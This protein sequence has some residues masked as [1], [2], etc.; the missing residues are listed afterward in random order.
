MTPEFTPWEKIA[1]LN[2]DIVI[3]EKIDGTN[4]AIGVVNVG[5]ETTGDI[6]QVYA[7]SR[8]R[9]ITPQAD[10]FGFAKWV[11][12]NANELAVQLGEGLHFGEWWGRGIQRGYGLDQQRFSL[13]NTARWGYL[14]DPDFIE[15]HPEALCFV[16]PVL[17]EGRFDQSAIETVLSLLRVSGS[18]AAPGY[19]KPEGVVIF[20]T[21]ANSMF[22]VTLEGDAKPKG[23]N[24]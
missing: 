15:A 2:R 8:T 3:T 11:A 14:A 16:V 6:F 12:D 13:F 20:H 23:V 17:Y 18:R 10:N 19:D 22:K 1:R 21:A 5:D 7:Q 9:I 4:A 24:G